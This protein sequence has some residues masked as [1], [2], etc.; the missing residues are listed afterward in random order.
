MKQGMTLQ[1]LSDT[2]DPGVSPNTDLVMAWHTLGGTLARPCIE[3]VEEDGAP[4]CRWFI[5]DTQ[6]VNINGEEMRWREFKGKWDSI[7]WCKANEW[8]PIALLR[9]F[10][11]NA[12]DGKRQA[13]EQA[14]GI[15]I[16]KGNK[17]VVCYP[18]S[19]EWLKREFA[20]F[21]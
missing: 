19:P 11:D 10:R 6:P 16:Q 7:E 8:H 2:E 4:Y 1:I 12:R 21:L 15:R 14:V 3:R 13:R 17:Q 18:N 9:A 20:K 5:D